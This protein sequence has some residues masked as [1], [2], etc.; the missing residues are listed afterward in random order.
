[1]ADTKISALTAATTV[2]DENEI[3][4]N[5]AGTNKK[6]TAL[7]IKAYLGDSLQNA[8]VADQVISA[9]TAYVAG[10][11]IAVPVGKLRIGTCLRWRI[12]V[13]KSAAGTTAGCAVLFK[14]GT[15]GTT[16]DATIL[17]FT[18]GTPT[19][20]ADNAIIDVDVIIQGPLSA[21]C[22][23][24]GTCTLVHNL[25]ATGFSTLPGEVKQVTSSAF[26]ATVANLI[27][28]IT[29]TTTASSAW[30]IK[31]VLAEAKNL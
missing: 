25:A 8:A 29:I 14:L 5:E 27:A 16:G 20:A 9:T 15:L 1:M 6:I 2:A 3:P 19:A 31:G 12:Q 26:D 21:S 17:T 11:A 24:E 4:I 30:T 22:I 23:A 28:G 18:L 7:Q 13:T 10:S